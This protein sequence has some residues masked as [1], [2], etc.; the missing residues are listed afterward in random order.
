MATPMLAKNV[1]TLGTDVG[2]GLC[3]SHLSYEFSQ[4]I[5]GKNDIHTLKMLVADGL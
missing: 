4:K 2:D 1:A 5:G 3:W